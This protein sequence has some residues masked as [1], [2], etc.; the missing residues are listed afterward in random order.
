MVIISLKL[1]STWNC[2]SAEIQIRRSFNS[3]LSCKSAVVFLSRPLGLYQRKFLKSLE[4]E[5][6][7]IML[8]PLLKL[9]VGREVQRFLDCSY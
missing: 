2:L 9:G 5:V 3:L 7:Q 1:M 4:N 6:S 8:P